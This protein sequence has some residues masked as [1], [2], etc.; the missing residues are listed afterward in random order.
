MQDAPALAEELALEP[1]L[2]GLKLLA[3]AKDDS[4]LPRAGV[5]GYPHWGR[6]AEVNTRFS[7]DILQWFAE[8]AQ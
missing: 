7:A 5:R 2:Q 4:L 1:A 3:W 6:W 8:G